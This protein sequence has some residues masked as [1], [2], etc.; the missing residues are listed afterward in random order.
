[1]EDRTR[2]V[3]QHST[4]DDPAAVIR[5]AADS[6]YEERWRGQ[7]YRPEV[8]IEKAALLGVVESVCDEFRVPYFATIGN[9]SQTL[10]HDAGNRFA[11]YLDQG[12]IP[13]VLHLADHDPN[14][15]DMTRD[16]VKGL[17]LYARADIEVRRIALTLP[18]V[19]QYA[20]P[21]N[22]AKE[23]D[24]RYAAYVTQFGTTD[25]WE[26][27]A[28]S[29]TVIADL[30]R[31]EITG[32]IDRPRWDA[33]LASEQRNRELLER[34]ADNWPNYFASCRRAVSRLKPKMARSDE[35]HEAIES[36]YDDDAAKGAKPSNINE[37]IKPVQTYLKAHGLHASR[38]AIRRI[39]KRPPFT[40]RRVPP[41]KR[42]K[43]K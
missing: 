11:G 23:T 22:F 27:D 4:W 35:I 13:L 26:L 5:S 25:C 1:M 29:A 16:I 38:D 21:P 40:A 12:L 36:I 30:I 37:L 24:S 2:E 14:G 10:L 8:W 32:L 6:Y 34:A 17:A 41:G 9:S 28:L 42:F 20:P 3:Y 33:A 18:Q 43:K 15:I 7:R 19:R 31:T 39:G